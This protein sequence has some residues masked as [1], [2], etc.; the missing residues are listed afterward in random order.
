[1]QLLNDF[2]AVGYGIPVLSEGDLVPINLAVTAPKVRTACMPEPHSRG[3]EVCSH[4]PMPRAVRQASNSQLAVMRAVSDLLS[5]GAQGGHGPWHW[6]WSCAADVG[7][8]DRRVPRLARW[9][10][11]SGALS[12]FGCVSWLPKLHANPKRAG[13]GSHATFAPR[14]W[15]QKA[16]ASY[17]TTKFGH[18]EIE[19]VS[20][21][22]VKRCCCNFGTP[23]YNQHRC[24]QS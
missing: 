18:C 14:G 12:V 24:C 17:V 23:A 1:M 16:L 20:C 7:W 2:E 15:K 8:Q 9:V 6:S 11:H 3:P 5:A 19:Q 13:E 22:L 21:L 10:K 4:A